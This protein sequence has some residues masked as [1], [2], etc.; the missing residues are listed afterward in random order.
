MRPNE[1]TDRRPRPYPKDDANA[2]GNITLNNNSDQ[3][4]FIADSGDTEHIIGK[5]LILSNFEKS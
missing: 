4:T 1:R 5:G 2:A 3:I